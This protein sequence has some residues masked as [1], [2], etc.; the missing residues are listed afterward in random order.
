MGEKLAARLTYLL[1]PIRPIEFDREQSVLQLRSSPPDRDEDST[2][3]YELVARRDGTLSL[4]R[5]AKKPGDVRRTIPV[6]VTREVF[7]RLVSDFS[8]AVA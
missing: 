6:N 5:Y 8:S 3:Y 1:E 4:C 2:S 7:F